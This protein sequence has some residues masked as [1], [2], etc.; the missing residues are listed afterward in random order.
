[1]PN[2]QVLKFYF[3]IKE[4]TIAKLECLTVETLIQV[5]K[6][7][8][9]TVNKI[10][11]LYKAQSGDPVISCVHCYACSGL[12]YAQQVRCYCCD[13]ILRFGF[14]SRV[15]R[16]QGGGFENRLCWTLEKRSR[17][18]HSRTTQYHSE[19]IGQVERMNRTILRM[20]R[21]LPKLHTSNWI[22]RLNKLHIIVQS[23]R[24]QGFPHFCCNLVACPVCLLT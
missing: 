15:H 20:I 9:N 2:I 19:G 11:L 1:M 12:S 16:D 21:F 8:K 23:T 24:R 7:Q 17:I 6:R 13:F 10:L 4:S 3:P 22:D 18:V 14:P 5:I